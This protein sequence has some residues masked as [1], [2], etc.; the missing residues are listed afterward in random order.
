MIYPGL[1]EKVIGYP[2]PGDI[3]GELG[4]LVMGVRTA[5]IRCTPTP[6]RFTH[7]PM[8]KTC[9]HIRPELKALTASHIHQLTLAKF[10]LNLS[11]LT[12]PENDND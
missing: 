8:F 4:V 3:L 7:M 5:A 1:E 12:I 6:D 10:A 11:T 2:D 9:L